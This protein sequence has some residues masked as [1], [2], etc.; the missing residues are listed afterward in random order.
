MFVRAPRAT[1]RRHSIP[2]GRARVSAPRLARPPIGARFHFDPQHLCPPGAPKLLRARRRPA[3]PLAPARPRLLRGPQMGHPAR[4]RCLWCAPAWM[5]K[6]G[7]RIFHCASYVL[8]I[9]IRLA[10]PEVRPANSAQSGTIGRKVAPQLE[11]NLR[12]NVRTNAWS[13]FRLESI[14]SSHLQPMRTSARAADVRLVISS[15]IFSPAGTST[16]WL[17]VAPPIRREPALG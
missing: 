9:H 7:H 6:V 12:P 17:A 3:P 10:R 16:R 1:T 8:I 15:T 2:I 11:A 5:E 13:Q 14:N 4:A